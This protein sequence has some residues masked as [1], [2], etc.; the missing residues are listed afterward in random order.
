VS[1]SPKNLILP[2]IAIGILAVLVQFQVLTIAFG[3]LGLSAHSAYLLLVLTLAG[4]M[5]N[6]PLFT[7]DSNFSPDANLPEELLAWARHRRYLFPGKTLI[8]VNVGGC[9]VPVA[10]SA[11]LFVNNN[12]SGLQAFICVLIVSIVAYSV[13]RPVR[14]LGIGMPMLFAPLA[15]A[16][17]AYVLARENAAPLAYISGTLGVLFGAD[18]LR[19]KDVR[20]LG[21]PIASIGGAG[22]FDG[23]FISGLLAVLLA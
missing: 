23:I 16:S 6:I 17:V 2:I 20:K 1:R 4:S 12:V 11:Y 9:V 7:I 22:S 18:L 8:L 3:K 15:A 21:T 5:L 19:F 14:G 10:F 13:S